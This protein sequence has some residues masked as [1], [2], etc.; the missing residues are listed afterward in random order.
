MA[1]PK[2]I[3]IRSDSSPEPGEFLVEEGY[4]RGYGLEVLVEGGEVG[5]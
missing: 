2:V 5:G 3:W 1:T 4:R